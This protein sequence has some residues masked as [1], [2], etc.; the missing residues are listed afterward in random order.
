M[1]H[2]FNSPP[3]GQGPSDLLD[4]LEPLLG[5]GQLWPGAGHTA[6]DISS[7]QQVLMHYTECYII[8]HLL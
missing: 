5:C 2:L 7:I 6:S 8:H 1:T 3:P 4:C